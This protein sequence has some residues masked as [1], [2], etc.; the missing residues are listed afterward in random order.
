MPAPAATV[1]ETKIMDLFAVLL[2]DCVAFQAFVEQATSAAA[3]AR[4][5][6]AEQANVADSFAMIGDPERWSIPISVRFPHGELWVLFDRDRFDSFGP[7]PRNKYHGR[8][9]FADRGPVSVHSIRSSIDHGHDRFRRCTRL[10][11][12]DRLSAEHGAE[13]RFG[14]V[15]L[16]AFDGCHVPPSI[17]PR[18]GGG[19]SPPGGPSPRPRGD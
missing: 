13:V 6:Q 7:V 15:T 17:P 12:S 11:V 9:C 14:H 10:A 1:G 4:I 16:V 19:F 5:Y 18:T 2:A 8:P 3:Y